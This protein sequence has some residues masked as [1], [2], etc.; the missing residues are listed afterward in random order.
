MKSET[1]S[2]LATIS[3]YF[4]ILEIDCTYGNIIGDTYGLLSQLNYY[5]SFVS[6]FFRVHPPFTCRVIMGIKNFETKRRESFLIKIDI[7]IYRDSILI[8][9]ECATG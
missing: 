1:F 9:V 2:T 8:S 4:T 6:A 7:A 5:R 3:V